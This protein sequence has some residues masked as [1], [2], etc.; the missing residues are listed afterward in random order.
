[1]INIYQGEDA[2]YGDIPF[3][4]VWGT[5]FCYED[6]YE[7]VGREHLLTNF[8]FKAGSETFCKFGQYI[9]GIICYDNNNLENVENYINRNQKSEQITINIDC[10]SRDL[11]QDQKEDLKNHSGASVEDIEYIFYSPHKR[12]VERYDSGEKIVPNILTITSESDSNLDED[13]LYMSYLADKFNHGTE[14]IR[15]EKEKYVG[16]KLAVHNNHIDQRLL[17]CL[18][19]TDEDIQTNR[20]EEH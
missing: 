4:I 20:S 9:T 10:R 15:Y 19:I 8:A 3:L 6:L 18:E 14:L 11:T 17:G 12:E 2:S 1:M 13:I 16:I 7:L 5:A